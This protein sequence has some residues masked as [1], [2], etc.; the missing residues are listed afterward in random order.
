MELKQQ[1]LFSFS[2]KKEIKTKI[3]RLQREVRDFEMTE[4]IKLKKA[5]YNMY[6]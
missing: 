4:P 1:G 2:K 5:Y 6:S 3:E